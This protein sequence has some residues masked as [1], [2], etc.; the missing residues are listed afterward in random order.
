MKTPHTLKWLAAL[1]LL[2][3]S[4]TLNAQAAAQSGSL[5]IGVFVQDLHGSPISHLD[6]GNFT[7]ANQGAPLPF[8]IIR[9]ALRA[10]AQPNAEPTRMLI[11]LSPYIKHSAPALNHLLPELDP[12]WQRGWQVAAVLSNGRRTDYAT[13]AIQLQQ[14]W[15]SPEINAHLLT[16]PKSAPSVAAIHDLDSFTGRRVVLYL[17]KTRNQQAKPTKQI[18][19]AA[20]HAMAQLFVVDGGELV[21]E[22]GPVSDCSN[23][24]PSLFGGPPA[25][26]AAQSSTPP[27]Y[28]SNC[29]GSYTKVSKRDDWYF[30]VAINAHVAIHEAIGSANG[31]YSLR[32]PRASL[33]ALPSGTPL[34]IK[35]HLFD[36]PN[37]TA[38]AIGYGNNPP[39][40]LLSKK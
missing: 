15:S 3:A 34:S 28:R 9:P 30:Y 5:H 13:N 19:S 40:I 8:Q 22:S 14:M 32:I 36:V 38:T 39:A 17:A 33:A 25:A 6:A 37:F 26:Q 31:Y 12:V 21:W 27:A 23:S 2:A 10:K 16:G 20:K 29:L 35:I 11:L 7:V 18:A 1:A 24:I 4:P